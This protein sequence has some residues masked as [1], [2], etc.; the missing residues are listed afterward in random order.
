MG[1]V[2]QTEA[3]TFMPEKESQLFQT[4]G[5]FTEE[6]QT[7]I[8]NQGGSH[9]WV[10]LAARVTILQ[11]EHLIFKPQLIINAGVMDSLRYEKKEFQSD[12]QD[13][14]VGLG[15]LMTVDSQT[16][17]MLTLSHLSGHVLED[18][19]NKSLIPV[20]VGDE[21][22]GARLIHD[23]DKYFRLGVDLK[24]I[25]GTEGGVERVNSDQ[26]VEWMPLGEKGWK[27]KYTP[28]L[29]VGLEE[30]GYASYY[31]SSHAQVGL[32]WGNHFEEKHSEV[33]RLV[34]G[35]YSGLDPR[36]KYAHFEHSKAQ[37][38]YGGLAYEY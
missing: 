15:L 31:L 32:Y 30:N 38:L 11:F 17:F 18:V 24:Y 37:F 20:D 2:Y 14:R 4:Y 33:V 12:T 22:L 28:Y 19:P 23:W 9:F 34:L 6:G 13:L 26:F 21:S 3:Q 35:Y 36:Q 1:A 27:S 29:A 7:A 16:R 5:L 8:F 10:E 25:F